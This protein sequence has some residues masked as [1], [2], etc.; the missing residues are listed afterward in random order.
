MVRVVVTPETGEIMT[1]GA[2]MFPLSTT[3]FKFNVS[4]NPVKIFPAL[5]TKRGCADPD[6][7][8][9]GNV[10]VYEEVCAVL[11]ISETP[12]SSLNPL[13]DG[14]KSDTCDADN[15]S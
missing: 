15:V 13:P 14:Y 9:E 1:F 3:L 7:N 2:V 4:G 11:R 10:K 12:T 6:G 5:D 8:V